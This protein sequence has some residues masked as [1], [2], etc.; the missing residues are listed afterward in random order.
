[1]GARVPALG[2]F[3]IF[4]HRWEI[5]GMSS[6]LFSIPDEYIYGFSKAV[7]GLQQAWVTSVLNSP[8]DV[9]SDIASIVHM[10][11]RYWQ[12]QMTLWM[13]AVASVDAASEDPVI[14]PAR[15]DRRFHGEQ[16]SSNAGWSLLKQ[17]Y[18]LNSKLLEEMVDNARLDEKN[19]HKLRFF[20]RQFIDAMSPANFAAT[21][22]DMQKILVESQGGSVAAGMA[23]LMA[24]MRNGRIS[25]TDE[26]AFEVGRNVALSEGSVVFENEL[27]QLIQYAPLTEQ[28]A[29][30]PLL[31]VP[32]CI[33][34]FYILDLQPENS[35]VRF[36][37]EQGLTVFLVS[38]RNPDA[39][40]AQTTWDD[41]IELGALKAIEVAHA[42][43]KSDKINTVGWCVGG[44]ILA[45]AIAVLRARD[46]DS[47]AS[48]TL[49][50]TMLDFEQPGDLGVFI[51]ETSVRQRELTIGKGGIYSG[52]ELGFVFQTLRANDLIWPYVVD[53]YLKGK[54]PA[55]FDLLYWNA[56]STNLPGPMYAWYLR[57]LYLE[58]N[59]RNPG[60]L[61]VCG[62]PLNLGYIDVPTYLLATQEDHIVPWQSA[63]RTLELIAGEVRFVLGASGH[64]AGVVNPPSKNKRGYWADGKQGDDPRAWLDSARNTPGSWWSDWIVWLKP[65]LGEQVAARSRLG[66][67]KFKPIEA[68]PGRYVRVRAD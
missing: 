22:P 52:K 41:Y 24:D 48:L 27:F 51:D 25:I 38:W 35:F 60:F 4:N 66:N 44:T 28:V 49:L 19:K 61:T 42:I 53:N 65:M 31:I 18:L 34:K 50:T 67:T 47:V 56:D 54:T 29:K 32:P 9:G 16:W 13:T 3:A 11:A 23:N 10:Q 36:A 68:A 63:Y 1:M 57:N 46:G 43:S 33:N 64:I 26:T 37:C 17:T 21:N 8:E 58:N 45:S 12:Q 2:C 20:V 30:R 7:G 5:N 15:G 40:L 39:S 6:S 62:T 14:S 59:L 55:A